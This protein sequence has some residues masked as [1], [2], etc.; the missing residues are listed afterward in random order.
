MTYQTRQLREFLYFLNIYLILL[1]VYVL[2]LDA[3]YVHYVNARVRGA[4]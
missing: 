2:C 3:G 4:Q 1:Y